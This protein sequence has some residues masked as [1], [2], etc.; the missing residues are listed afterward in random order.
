MFHRRPR[1]RLQTYLSMGINAENMSGG[2]SVPCLYLQGG[3]SQF[4][5]GAG[6]RE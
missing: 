3:A 5:I 4:D 6:F 1:N 2:P